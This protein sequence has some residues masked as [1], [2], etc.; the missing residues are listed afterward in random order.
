MCALAES[1]D[2]SASL[3]LSYRSRILRHDRIVREQRNALDRRLRHENTI[4]GVFMNRWQALDGNDVVADNRQF[5]VT[6]VQQT[7]A[8]QTG[9]DPKVFSPQSTLDRYLPQAG[10]TEQQ[11]VV[12]VLQ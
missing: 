9:L 7:T 8:Q 10:S 5:A 6:V 11:L 12:P 2:C 1:P 4:K 3:Q